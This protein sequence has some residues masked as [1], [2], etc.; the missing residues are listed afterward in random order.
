MTTSAIQIGRDATPAVGSVAMRDRAGES[1]AEALSAVE[2][3]HTGLEA[4]LARLRPLAE[5]G[6]MAATV[7]HEIR[8]PL[9][10][11]SANAELLRESLADP[12][13]IESVDLIL[14]E[15][16]RLGHL[17][18]DLLY[19]SRERPADHK[20]I[21]LGW[22]ARTV[23]ELSGPMA[24]AAGVELGYQGDGRAWGES[25]LARQALLNVVRNAIQATPR[26]GRVTIEVADRRVA[27]ADTGCGVPE[28]IRSKLFEPFVTGRSRGLGLG[29]SVAKRCMERQG[30]AITLA[31]T[32]PAGSTFVLTWPEH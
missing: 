26:G 9:T 14:G 10:G 7:A 8:N 18:S 1:A 32:S 3:N 16:A 31:A 27:V 19:Y 21:D 22:L 5:M 20:S 25:D 6:R 24:V 12:A 11:I 15:V 30:G 17:V 13:D 28:T 23:S 4:E 2:L 29:G